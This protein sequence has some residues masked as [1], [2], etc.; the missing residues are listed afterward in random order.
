MNFMNFAPTRILLVEPSQQQ[1][2]IGV[3]HSQKV[4]EIVSDPSRQPSH[5]FH[6]LSLKKSLLQFSPPGDVAE[7]GEGAVLAS[8]RIDH[9]TA[10]EP[11]PSHSPVLFPQPK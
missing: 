10:R 4:I 6:F 2:A 11:R 7:H 8:R 3:D 1:L 5:H 9:R